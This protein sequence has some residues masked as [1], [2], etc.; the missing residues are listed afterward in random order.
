MGGAAV[1]DPQ[2]NAGVTINPA[3]VSLTERYDVQ[4]MFIAGPDGALR[5][6]ASAVD[7]RTNKFMAFGLAYNGGL[8]SGG[9]HPDELPAWAPADQELVNTRQL[10]DITFAV[11]VPFLDRRLAVGVNGTLSIFKGRYVGSGVTGNLDLGVA[12][13]PIDQLQVG[14]VGKN[15]LPV[16]GQADLPAE[17]ALG[18]RGGLEDKIVGATD[19]SYQLEQRL[20]DTSP[21]SASA[22]VEGGIKIVRLRGG[23][24]WSGRL[25]E[26]RVAWGLGFATP[27]GSLDYAM[28]IPVATSDF[29]FASVTH[30][31][32]L[33]I[34]TNFGD[35]QAEEAP[36]RWQDR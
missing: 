20:E 3:T 14:L 5:W 27:I 33:T 7:G 31:L 25:Q 1:A 18:A 4:G 32:S 28:Q 36:I 21:W 13:R 23:W 8:L 29:T 11:S 17:L 15:I 30:T 35:R 19:V 24:D 2:D 10:H 26:H 34:R 16:A 9:F 22:G 12:T 6:N